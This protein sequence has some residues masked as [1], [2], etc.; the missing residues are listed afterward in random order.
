MASWVAA[1]AYCTKRSIRFAS[2]RSTMP[3]LE[4]SFTSHAKRV[5]YAVASNRVMVP[6]PDF[7]AVRLAQ[8]AS[9]LFPSGEMTPVPVT[10]TRRS[11]KET[12]PPC[13][14][15]APTGR[16]RGAR[17]PL[18]PAARLRVRIDHVGLGRGGR[19]RLE[20][21][22]GV[23]H[24]FQLVGFLVGDVEAELLLEGHDEFHDVE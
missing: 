21:V 1:T 12:C 5:E 19:V 6:A 13:G 8:N 22:H 23:A 15:G 14:R 7:P 11:P 4:K 3:L 17:A 16:D 18:L 2:L 10:K 9:V 24:G 20:V